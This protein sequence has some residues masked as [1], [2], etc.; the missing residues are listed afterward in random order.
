MPTTLL[1]AKVLIEDWRI[2]Y[3]L[4]RPHSAHGDLTP[5]ESAVG[6]ADFGSAM[7]DRRYGGVWPRRR[8]RRL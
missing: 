8:R 3:N 1:E 5:S 7:A 6:M 2:D 4:N